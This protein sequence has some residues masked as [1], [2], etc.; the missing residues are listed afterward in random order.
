[1]ERSP[2]DASDHSIPASASAKNTIGK[3]QIGRLSERAKARSSSVG[4]SAIN[5]SSTPMPNADVDQGSTSAT[6]TASRS[7]CNRR[8]SGS[9]HLARM[10][11]SRETPGAV[12][13]A[14]GITGPLSPSA[15]KNQLERT[16]R[17]DH[18]R[19]SGHRPGGRF[20]DW[21]MPKL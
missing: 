13:A 7:A 4:T 3:T 1:M 2:H 8:A 19:I 20:S 9:R 6:R 12:V 11:E 16:T 5:Q 18:A 10:A 21:I 14:S 17:G 15:G